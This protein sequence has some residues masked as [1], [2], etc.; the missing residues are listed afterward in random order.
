MTRDEILAKAREAHD[1]EGCSCDPKYI[2]SCTK[3]VNEILRLAKGK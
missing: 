2:M 3:L 1:R